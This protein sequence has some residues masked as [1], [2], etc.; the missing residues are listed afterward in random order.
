[1]SEI[2]VRQHY[3]YTRVIIVVAITTCSFDRPTSKLFFTLHPRERRLLYYLYSVARRRRSVQRFRRYLNRGGGG[4]SI[5]RHLVLNN[6]FLYI[7]F[8]SIDLVLILA[9]TNLEPSF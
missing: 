5:L 3:I 9:A 6:I 8:H 1:M 2:P 7:Y 4:F